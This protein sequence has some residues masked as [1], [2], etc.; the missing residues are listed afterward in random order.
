[1]LAGHA[2]MIGLPALL[3]GFLAAGRRTVFPGPPAHALA[4]QR[5]IRRKGVAAVRAQGRELIEPEALL[6]S[7]IQ[8]ATLMGAFISIEKFTPMIG[9]LLFAFLGTVGVYGVPALEPLYEVGLAA[10]QTFIHVA[11]VAQ[12]IHRLKERLVEPA[13]DERFGSSPFDQF[14]LAVQ[15]AAGH[16]LQEAIA[17]LTA[18][19]GARQ[20]R[21]TRIGL[22]DRLA[23][24]V[25]SVVGWANSVIHHCTL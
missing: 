9:C 5:G 14:L 7:L 6:D 18:G 3:V 24:Y 21:A 23:A 16:A 20:A 4:V 19:I 8:F 22:R 15:F 17:G 11:T 25:A 10:S 2:M 13:F 12:L 1:M